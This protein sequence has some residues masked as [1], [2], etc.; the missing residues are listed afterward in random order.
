[1][2]RFRSDDWW[3][4]DESRGP[5]PADGLVTSKQRGAMA[6]T[7]WSQ[8]FVAMLESYGL[9]GRMQRGRRYA[10]TG[11]V[12]SLEVMP[13][14]LRAEVQG[15]RPT[16]YV[17][18][19]E[20]KPPSRQQ[21]DAIEAVLA[22][23]V[24]FVARLLAGEVP[25]ELEAVFADASVDLFPPTWSRLDARC[26]CPDW[27]NPCKHIAAVLYVFA[28]QLDVDPWLLL[29][30][31]GRDRDALLSPIVTRG[32]ATTT[33]RPPA[34]TPWW[35]FAD[36]RLPELSGVDPALVV[37]V[38]DPPDAVLRRLDPLPIAVRGTPIVDL[39]RAAYESVCGADALPGVEAPVRTSGH[40]PPN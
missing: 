3:R 37:D 13:A 21:W 12:L 4:Y 33:P 7:W 11:Q 31:R 28:D 20:Y 34:I 22:A 38:P 25:P 15:S 40:N 10:R 35:P 17:V 36:A 8:R 6:E 19:I 32:A 5:L 2:P 18:T 27:G 30:W 16:P 29:A 23:R 9:G 39:L 14:V 26:N 1:M 24:G